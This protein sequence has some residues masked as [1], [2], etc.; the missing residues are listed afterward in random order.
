MNFFYFRI[1]F[2]LFL[3]CFVESKFYCFYSIHF[4][5]VFET[6]RLISLIASNIFF[7]TSLSAGWVEF[8]EGVSTLSINSTFDAHENEGYLKQV[9]RH[10]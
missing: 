2:I 9:Y 3:F 10:S 1:I 7:F 6:L 8:Q 4:S 5:I